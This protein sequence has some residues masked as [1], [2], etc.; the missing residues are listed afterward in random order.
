MHCSKYFQTRRSAWQLFH[1]FLPRFLRS[2]LVF[3][4]I[5]SANARTGSDEPR[6]ENTDQNAH[7]DVVVVTGSFEPLPLGEAD[8]SVTQILLQDPALLFGSVTDALAL[9]S[10]VNVQ[11]RG[12]GGVQADF[13][14][15]GGSYGQTLLLLNGI[16]MND[17][18]SGHYNSDIPVPLD[19]LRS[20]EVL[21]GSGSTLYGSDAV[22]GAI[23]L[24]TAPL[25]APEDKNTADGIEIRLR[26]DAGTFSTE[27]QSGF[28]ALHWGPWSQRWSFEREQSDGFRDNREYRNLALGSETWLRSRLGLTRIYLGLVDRPFGADQFY[29]SFNSWERTKTWLGTI[30][31]DLGKSTVVT[32]GYRRHTD[33]FELLRDNPTYYTNRHQDD[34]W[35]LALRR[36]D[37]LN[38]YVQAFYGLEGTADHV[39]S[40]NLGLHSR[41]QGALYGGVDVRS[42]RRASVTAGVREQFY[43]AGNH[44]FVPNV[45]AGYWLSAKWKLR[46]AASRAFR[47]PSYT[48]LYYSDPANLGNPNLKPEKATEYEGG[49]DWHPRERLELSFTGFDRRE[50]DGIDYVRP[51]TT[52][53]W[54]ATN[55]DRV[56]FAGVEAALRW[57]LTN[58]QAI[59][60]QFTGLRGQQGV[61]NGLQSKYVFNYPSEQ[62]VVAWQHLSRSGWLAR[63]RTGVTNQYARSS[64]VLLDA[65]AAW[66][67]SRFHPYVRGTNLLNTSYQP[68]FGI[69][70]PGRALQAGLEVC[71][72]CKRDERP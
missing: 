31:Q 1:M 70:M 10:S 45:S 22:G 65:S 39:E 30:S 29:G 8:R 14:I 26:A 2:L 33:L 18:Q 57:S 16:R 59:D 17:E 7:H 44:I 49:I 50:R 47:L 28:A 60:V 58:K 21:R 19:A 67:R 27:E 68:I 40:T 46:G 54:Q 61:L 6:V 35:D 66:T 36:H 48:D 34:G 53:I 32:L 63:V 20:V 69:P 55:F 43:G 24:L 9:D 15:R 51:N 4:F 42:L 38:R 72:L 11:A 56:Q 5:L 62:A 13:S 12:A 41:K 71:V 3:A 52:A 37:G 25:T 64:Y 23:N